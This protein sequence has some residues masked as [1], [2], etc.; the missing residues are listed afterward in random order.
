[1]WKMLLTSEASQPVK[2]S[3][4][5]EFLDCSVFLLVWALMGEEALAPVA[6]GVSEAL[7]SS[8]PYMYRGSSVVI[9]RN[10]ANVWKLNS[11]T[12][13][14]ISQINSVLS[15][16]S[17]APAFSYAALQLAESNSWLG[18]NSMVQGSEKV[19]F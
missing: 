7:V 14:K 6:L 5:A 18:L 12:I 2:V 1:M 3:H 15:N 11:E 8:S 16:L 4:L 13:T 19:C 10:G 9:G 17:R